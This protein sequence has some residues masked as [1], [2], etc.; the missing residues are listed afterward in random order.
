MSF[1][2]EA[3]SF[4]FLL[5]FFVGA[6]LLNNKNL[7]FFFK[8]SFH[9]A[10]MHA[11]HI[12]RHDVHFVFVRLHLS[13][14][15]EVHSYDVYGDGVGSKVDKAFGARRKW[16]DGG[17]LCE[18]TEKM[19]VTWWYLWKEKFL[20]NLF[21]Q[22]NRRKKNQDVRDNILPRLNVHG[23]QHSTNHIYFHWLV[24]SGGIVC[25]NRLFQFY[26]PPFFVM[27]LHR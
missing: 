3:Y 4:L 12:H 11:Q 7:F 21:S 17:R 1:S 10:F 23:V 13:N 25:Y 5:F 9:Q 20:A 6:T 18:I 16:I 27:L 19:P 24:I 26:S 15:I 8:T 22:S 14:S 2:S